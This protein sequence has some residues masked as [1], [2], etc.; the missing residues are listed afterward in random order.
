LYFVSKITLFFF[1]VCPPKC[2]PQLRASEAG[3]EGV[4]N[5][6]VYT[7]KSTYNLCKKPTAYCEPYLGLSLISA[8][9]G[10]GDGHFLWDRTFF[11]GW[12]I[13]YE[14]GHFLWGR[15]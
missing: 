15:T 9:T 6:E 14:M 5:N 2:G 4:L 10:V 12:D 3:L 8:F 13:F 11:I 1:Q 7:V